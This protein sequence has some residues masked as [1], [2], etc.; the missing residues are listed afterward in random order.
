LYKPE[1]FGWHEQE[2]LAELNVP[3]FIQG[4]MKLHDGVVGIVVVI[5]HLPQSTGQ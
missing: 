1:K 5:W 4:N 3:P 2:Q